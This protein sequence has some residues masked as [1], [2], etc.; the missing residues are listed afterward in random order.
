MWTDGRTDGR[1][2]QSERRKSA[3]KGGSG[4]GGEKGV[5]AVVRCDGCGARQ[6]GRMAGGGMQLGEFRV[7]TCV[8]TRPW[9]PQQSA[10]VDE[11]GEQRDQLA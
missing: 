10:G 6:D 7:N 8:P 2:D 5:S 11:E 1:T 9:K 4:R 3:K